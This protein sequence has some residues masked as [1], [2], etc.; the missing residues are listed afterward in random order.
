MRRRRDLQETGRRR[1]S[2]TRAGRRCSGAIPVWRSGPRGQRRWVRSREGGE[3]VGVLRRGILRGP[4]K[5]A[6]ELSTASMPEQGKRK[7]RENRLS[8]ARKGKR[9][10]SVQAMPRRGRRRGGERDPVSGSRAG[11]T[12]TSASRAT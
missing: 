11:A 4:E 6:V 2:P 7:V 3:V 12:E 1:C 8:R 10:G 5:T 9:G